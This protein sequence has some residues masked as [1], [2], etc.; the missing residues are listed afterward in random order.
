LFLYLETPEMPMH[1]GSLILFRKPKGQRGSFY[2]NIR[3]HVEGRMHLAPLFSR[4]LAFMPLDLTN[5]V[6]VG[7]QHVDLDHHITRML[8]PKPGTQAQL[9]AAVAKRHEGMLDRDRP[10][11]EFTVIEGLQSGLVAFYA[12]IHHAALD[13]QGGVALAQAVLDTEPVQL[14]ATAPGHHASAPGHRAAAPRAP[15]TARMLGAAFRNTVA[16]YGKIIKA[17]PGVIRLARDAGAALLN[18]SEARKAGA[19]S[20]QG[21]GI[22]VLGDIKPGDTLENIARNLLKKIPGGIALGPRS[23]FNVAISAERDFVATQIRSPKPK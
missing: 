11:W 14:A 2:K 5:P 9:E 22:P 19:P 7:E 15:G 17:V 10:L 4:K 12:K 13:G 16:Q 1:V 8:L 3:T 20:E 23:P 18:A 6:W 21:T